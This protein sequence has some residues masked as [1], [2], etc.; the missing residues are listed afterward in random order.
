MSSLGRRLERLEKA[1]ASVNSPDVI[2]IEAGIE[3][4]RITGIK[5]YC[6]GESLELKGDCKNAMYAKVQGLLFQTLD[7]RAIRLVFA[8]F[9]IYEQFDP[10]SAH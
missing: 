4:D 10:T 2:F 9:L 6:E 3:P 1:T 7:G 5:F 8:E